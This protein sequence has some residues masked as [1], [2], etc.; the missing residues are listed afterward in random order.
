MQITHEQARTLIQFSLDGIL[1]SAE[2]ALLSAHLH[3][4]SECQIYASEIKE[5]EH[6]LAPL[7]KTQWAKRPAPLS[8][9]WLLEKSQKRQSSPLLTMRTATVTLVLL[10]IFFSAWRFV[11]FTP[12]M[13]DPAP[14]AVPLV[15]T[16]SL[17]TAQFTSTTETCEI[18]IYTVESDDTLS[19]IAVRFSVAKED[20]LRINDLK[21]DSVQP[22]T[23]LQ[24]PLCN[25]TPTGTIHPATFTTTYTPIIR[26]TTS[27]PGG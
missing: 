16:P 10:V 24:I 13:A 25:R 12:S 9:S 21:T 11:S 17:L 20:L 5:V 15:P 6:I 1:Q 19:S 3:D 18:L 22:S 7:V 26:P 2:K 14:L 27:T 8:I 23:K 4:C